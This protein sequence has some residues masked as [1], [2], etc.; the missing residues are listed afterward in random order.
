MGF[1]E[2]GNEVFNSIKMA[3]NILTAIVKVMSE[4]YIKFLFSFRQNREHQ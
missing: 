4:H 1:C 2:H 3:E